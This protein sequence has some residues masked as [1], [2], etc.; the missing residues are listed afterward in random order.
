VAVFDRYRDLQ[1]QQLLHREEPPSHVDARRRLKDAGITA[2]KI[3]GVRSEAVLY[4]D[5]EGR[6]MTAWSRALPGGPTVGCTY[7]AEPGF[8]AEPGMY[9]GDKP[10]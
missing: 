4:L 2:K 8:K 7:L 5:Q 10:E 9:L 1:E 6:P 3:I